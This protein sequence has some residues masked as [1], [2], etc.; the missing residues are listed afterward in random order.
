MESQGKRS[1]S[2]F[3]A[4]DCAG[5]F[6]FPSSEEEDGKRVM[7]TPSC[8]LTGAVSMVREVLSLL[9]VFCFFYLAMFWGKKMKILVGGEQK[10]RKLP[11]NGNSDITSA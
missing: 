5:L 3:T 4:S 11:K 2:G 7:S 8:D 10:K 6:F 1:E 9:L